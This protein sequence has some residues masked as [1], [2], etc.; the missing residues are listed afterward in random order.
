MTALR[1]P[2]CGWTLVGLDHQTPL[3]ALTAGAACGIPQAWMVTGCALHWATM[4]VAMTVLG[5]H[6]ASRSG[7]LRTSVL[8][9][10]AAVALHVAAP[11]LAVA[12]QAIPLAAVLAVLV[13]TEVLRAKVRMAAPLAA[14]AGWGAMLW[15]FFAG[16][17][18]DM[19]C[20]M[21]AVSLCAVF[22]R[23]VGF[24]AV[25]LMTPGWMRAAESSS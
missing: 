23:A 9:G 11:S 17:P 7:R 19:V 21:L 10:A 2:L 4:C 14:T 24:A 16:T 1:I 3:A 22:G 8:L 13:L 18:L 25:G 20:C 5:H 15:C 6:G 12:A